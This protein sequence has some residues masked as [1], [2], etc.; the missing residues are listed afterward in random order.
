MSEYSSLGLGFPKHADETGCDSSPFQPL[1]SV[2]GGHP[3]RDVYGTMRVSS[4]AGRGLQARWT[5]A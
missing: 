1:E 4:P 5:L 2:F 3:S